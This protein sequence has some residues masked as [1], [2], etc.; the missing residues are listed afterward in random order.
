V[1]RP[2]GRRA[3]A[4]TLEQ[5]AQRRVQEALRQFNNDLPL[6]LVE[7]TELIRDRSTAPAVRVQLIQSVE[8]II[9][10]LPEE[11]RSPSPASSVMDEARELLKEV[12]AMERDHEVEIGS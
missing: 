3:G 6:L 4:P 8:R 5:R 12:L 11:W 2:T 9:A 10:L 7:I 1:S